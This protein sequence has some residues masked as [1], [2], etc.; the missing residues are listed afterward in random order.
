MHNDIS[1]LYQIYHVVS[2]ARGMLILVIKPGL[3]TPITYVVVTQWTACLH[4]IVTLTLIM[5]WLFG[6]STSCIVL[7]QN[8]SFQR[9]PI[10]GYGVGDSRE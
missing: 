6:V 8:V 4:D 10:H 3:R 7:P 9:I 5:K 2:P 1:S